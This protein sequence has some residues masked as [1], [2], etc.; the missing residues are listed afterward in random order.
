M[1]SETDVT[2]DCATRRI[3]SRPLT[4][5]GLVGSVDGTVSV[6]DSSEARMR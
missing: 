6:R 1:H 4:H 5:C 2:R 3:R